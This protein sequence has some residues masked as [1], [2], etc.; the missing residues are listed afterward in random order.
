M[1]KPSVDSWPKRSSQAFAVRT[2]V[3]LCHAIPRVYPAFES[4]HG[5]TQ[6]RHAFMFSDPLVAGWV[7]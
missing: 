5:D 1:Q 6:T 7:S 4:A 3:R 2:I